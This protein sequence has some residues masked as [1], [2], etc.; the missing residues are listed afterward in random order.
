MKTCTRARMALNDG[1]F[2]RSCSDSFNDRYHREPAVRKADLRSAGKAVVQRRSKENAESRPVPA[3][4]LPDI[5]RRRLG[6]VRRCMRIA[7][8]PTRYYVPLTDT[9][10]SA[11]HF[12][13]AEPRT[14]ASYRPHQ[15][16]LRSSGSTG[17]KLLVIKWLLLM[18]PDLR[19]ALTCGPSA[20]HSNQ[21]ALKYL[22]A[23]LQYVN[24]RGKPLVFGK[25]S[26]NA[27]CS[28]WFPMLKFLSH[29]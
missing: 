5:R 2:N 8:R 19:Y 3:E 11:S 12:G 10:Q 14:D 20:R 22:I 17:S 24:L 13:L 16:H 28:L 7:V 1:G 25:I 18:R 4:R 23:S 6:S 9:A 27:P 26:L 15:M 29:E 21:I